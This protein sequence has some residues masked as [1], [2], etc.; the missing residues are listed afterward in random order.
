MTP[1]GARAITAGSIPGIASTGDHTTN[2]QNVTVLPPEAL[3]APEAVPAPT[4]LINLPSRLRLFVGREDALGW[5]DTAAGDLGVVVVQAVHGLGGIGK[6][7]LVA[8]WAATHRDDHRP[9]W[10][11]TADSPTALDAGL[12][13]L[14]VALQ[15]VLGAVLP[16][17]ALREWALRWLACHDEWLLIL[18]NVTDPA[19]FADL[20]GRLPR[21]RILVTSRR[22][23]GWPDIVTP[24][25]LNV[26]E[27]DQ[28]VEL[29]TEIV[30]RGGVVVDPAGAAAVCAELG[31]LPLAV[32]QAGAYLAQTGVTAGDYLRLLA[33]HP[34]DMYRDGEEGRAAEHTIARVWQVTL[35]ALADDPL[36]GR[37]LRAL[38]WYAPEAISHTL[39]Q[40]LGDD[41]EGEPAVVRAVGR[42]A[43]YNMLTID[44]ASRAITVH[45]LVQAV[46]RIPDPDDPHRQPD[47]MTTACATATTALTI[48]LPDDWR[49]P[50]AWPTWRSL[51]PHI[52][53]LASHARAHTTDSDRATQAYLLN[54]A[55]VF[56]H[57]QGNLPRASA[58]LEQALTDYRR[59]L[60]DDHPQTLTSVNDLASTYQAAGDL[61]RA[62]LL[63]EQSL[64]D[65]RRVLGDDH[66]DTLASVNNLASTYRSAGN[67]QRAI[68][69]FEQALTDYRR[70][71]GDDHPDTLTSVNN[72]AGAYRSAGDL[73]RAILLFEQAF[74]DRRRV[75]G[76]DHPDTLASV[77]NLAST[78]Q[79][80]GDLQRAILLFEQSLT[81]RRRVLGDDH[82]QTLT[83]V[84]NL[85]STYRS[86]RDLQRA[87]PL[88]EQSL[89]DR[90][91]V[92]GDD[93]PD[94]LASVN[95]LAS[96][97]HA[98][99]DLQR[100]IPLFEQA[101]TDYRRVLGDDHPDTLASVNNLA[102]A[103]RS[104]GDLQ[105]A[106][107]L[108]EQA[109]TDRRR[110][111]GDDH[112]QTLTSVNDLAGAYRSARD[113]QRAIPL[114]EQ[115]LT[116]RRRVLGDDHPQTLTSVN[117]LAGAYRSA[118]DLQRAI[119]LYEQALTDYR[120]VLGDDHP[121]TLI[122]VNNLAGAYRSAGDLQRAILLFEQALTDCQRA[123]GSDH[124][125]TRVVYGNLRAAMKGSSSE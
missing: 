115:S 100:A 2:T 37:L 76:D 27:L 14:T 70:V 33:Q 93:H 75:L 97:Y 12:V 3:V 109:L 59:V 90:R 87:I 58:Y 83:S 61:Q 125:V 64:T 79:A 36:P 34:A 119:S 39:W 123:L 104:A 120:R 98:A 118:G 77:N 69:L 47:D 102:G 56:L 9:I 5:L 121:D 21:G 25:R 67:L 92:L 41:G 35:D 63:F 23:T 85:A 13:A 50:I 81:D 122:S 91:R 114:F 55:G 42:L 68:P 108:F 8:Q 74:T 86:A 44:T 20:L 89:T 48:A 19:H 60:G 28:A 18:D 31:C 101:L 38:A 110:V 54:A 10:W 124:P 51:V 52:D 105:R 78:Y 62:I 117:D 107:L 30:S 88:F 46:A 80:A 103:Y 71:L 4:G 116:D 84:N 11:I 22:A 65:R 94:T 106:I 40:H 16:S 113:L 72:L 57:G 24:L 53:A 1:D 43:A 112:P 7:T 6:S 26:L 32:E 17:P 29:L 49:D 95:N 82:P 73:Q 111:L 45:R 66:P 99:G 96:T 15:P